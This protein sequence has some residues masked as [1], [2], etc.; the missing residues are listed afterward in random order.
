LGLSSSSH[1]LPEF[2]AL[3]NVCIPAFI[4]NKSKHETEIRGEKLLD[5]AFP[6]SESQK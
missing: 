3:E 4:A 5:W 6:Q 1:Q 2:T